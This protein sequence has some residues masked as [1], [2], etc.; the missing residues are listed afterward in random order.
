MFFI[1][2]VLQ[3]YQPPSV[4]ILNVGGAKLRVKRSALTHVD[5]SKLA[6][7]FSGRWDHVLPRNH[8]GRKFLDLDVK[9]FSPITDFL[10]KLSSGAAA[11]EVRLPVSQL[12]DD[13]KLGV[14]AC[15][16]MFGLCHILARELNLRPLLVQQAL[17]NLAQHV[18]SVAH[19]GQESKRVVGWSAPWQLLY[20]SSVHGA[21]AQEFHRLCDCKPHTICLAI[22]NE[23]NMFGGYTSVAWTSSDG[24][25]ADPAAFLFYEGRGSAALQC[26]SQKGTS[27]EHSIRHHS[28]LWPTFGGGHDLRFKSSSAGTI[29]YS[30]SSKTYHTMPINGTSGTVID[31]FVWQVP[32]TGGSAPAATDA[33]D[34]V[35]NQP[36]CR[37]S[38]TSDSTPPVAF[39]ADLSSL[40]GPATALSFRFGLWLKEQLD[41][42][43]IELR[44]VKHR[45]EL[46]A[47][48]KTFMQQ[49][50]AAMS[51][52]DV[53]GRKRAWLEKVRTHNCTHSTGG[54]DPP[55]TPSPLKGVHHGIVYITCWGTGQLCTM[56]ETFTQLGDET[57]LAKK[58][59]SD[60]WAANIESAA[61]DE[62]GCV[63]EDH[64][65]ECFQKLVNV[66]RLRAMV[67]R[68]DFSSTVGSSKPAPM[69]AHLARAMA[70]MLEYLMID[71]EQ[72]FGT[73]DSPVA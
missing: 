21:T 56:R 20:Q 62:D 52:D 2:A 28:S 66:M 29:T 33:D 35:L 32:Q 6:W 73:L 25:Q 4:L 16:E 55:A 46:F 61:L 50:I 44:A 57:P 63:I 47:S 5:D 23:G 68:P 48:E 53:N 45:T 58:Y 72:F 27:P 7:M 22:D 41:M 3:E 69:P 38:Y 17:A 18:A 59:A 8:S 34:T 39:R 11:D 43:A 70:S 10:S 19:L 54:T 65:A 15:A 30:S 31:L 12:S 60:V 51:P 1:V 71:S 40:T 42:Y 26:Y 24:W 13:D 49:L 9:W 14:Q 36:A 64:N 37:L 67:R